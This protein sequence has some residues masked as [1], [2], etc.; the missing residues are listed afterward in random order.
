MPCYDA[1]SERVRVEYRNDPIIQELKDR[2]DKV[3]RL[4]C[5]TLESVQSGSS[6]LFYTLKDKE[7]HEDIE[8]ELVDWWEEHKKIDEEERIKHLEENARERRKYLILQKLHEAFGEEEIEELKE[9][10]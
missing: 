3:T 5:F 9:L 6:D 8:R 10:L 1:Q 7:F 2:L 4:L